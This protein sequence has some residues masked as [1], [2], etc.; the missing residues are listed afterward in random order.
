M[1]GRQISVMNAEVLEALG[2]AG[3]VPGDNLIVRGIDLSAFDAGDLLRIG[4]AILV[5]TGAA[6]NPCRKF[7]ERTSA[8]HYVAVSER[9][10]RGAMFDA[11]EPATI[12]VGDAVE[13]IV[14]E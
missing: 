7:K 11:R 1:T 14:M 13:R 8:A 3:D 6:H 9:R 12:T 10:R 2:V 5:A 4:D